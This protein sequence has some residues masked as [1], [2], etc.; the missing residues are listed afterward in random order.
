MRVFLLLTL[1]LTLCAGL[2]A[3]AL[4]CRQVQ[5]TTAASGNSPYS[6]Q[7][8]TVQGIVVAEVFYTGSSASNM[9]FV[10]SDPAGGPWSGLLIYTNVYHPV[11]GDIVRV[12]GP[13]VE[14]YQLT[15]MSLPTSYEVISQGNTLPP[16]SPVTTGALANAATA[17]QWESVFVKVENVNITTSPNSNNEFN[18]NDG[19]GAC[20]IDDQCFPRSGFS[21]PG[22]AIG[23]NWARIQGV[24]DYGFSYYAIN[25]RE[26]TDLTQVDDASSASIRIANTSA[27]LNDLVNVDIITS[28][29][30]LDW[31][32]SSYK[33]KIKINPDKV[34]FHGLMF[35]DTMS[36]TTWIHSLYVSPAGDTIIIDYRSLTDPLYS[37]VDDKVLIKLILQ[38]ISYGEIPLELLEF[39]YDST[40]VMNLTNGKLLVA[41]EEKMAWLNISN[42]ETG[43]SKNSFNPELNE[44]IAIEYGCKKASTGINAR[45]FVR[46]YDSQGRLVATPV[47]KVI[48]NPLGIE[49]ETWDGRDTNMKLVPIGMYYCHFEVIERNTGRKETTVQPIVVK[50]NLK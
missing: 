44:E 11:R 4:T 19:S 47:N 45:A 15:E 31:G 40:E 50:S 2:S 21:W 27:S 39:A 33:A 46:I 22:L 7:S 10:I 17:E 26:L 29:V 49:T 36:D 25:P 28:R 41:I 24:V 30:K 6:G 8:V 23:Q 48:S 34:L 18:V 37:S 14:Y 13:I 43:S 9:G 12:T 32:I 16:A 5:E 42:A 38:P 20:Q 1:A 35:T 3:Q